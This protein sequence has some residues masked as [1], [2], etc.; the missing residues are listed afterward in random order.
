MFAYCRNNPVR[1]RDVSGTTDEEIFGDDSN[2]LDDDKLIHGG[3]AKNGNPSANNGFSG[4]GGANGHSGHSEN[5]GN[6]TSYAYSPTSGGG[7]STSS[8]QVGNTT[9]TFG[10]GGRHVGFSD[11]SGLESAIA[12]DVVTR[13]PTTGKS[14]SLPLSYGGFDFTYRY[15]TLSNT[16]IH[17]GTYFF[18]VAK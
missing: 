7:G 4:N 12:N 14:V 2:L 6:P 18:T 17:V 15:F 3:T 8:V 10:H 11:I 16:R 5:S 1:R 9:V 13:P